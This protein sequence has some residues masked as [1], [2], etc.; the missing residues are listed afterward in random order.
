[1]IT[2]YYIQAILKTKLYKSVSAYL[3]MAILIFV[4][5]L[6]DILF[7]PILLIQCIYNFIMRWSDEQK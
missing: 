1:M 3:F 6:A 2:Y 7:S 4:S 5:I